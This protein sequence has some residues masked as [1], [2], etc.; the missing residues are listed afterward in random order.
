MANR[1][2]QTEIERVCKKIVEGEEEF[3][4]IWN[5]LYATEN[6]NQRE[7]YEQDLKREIKKLQRYRDQIKGWIASND[8]KDKNMLVEFR[9]RIEG[10]MERFKTCEKEMKTKAYSKEGLAAVGKLDPRERGKVE[11]QQWLSQAI[12]SLIT[13]VDQAEAE[14]ETMEITVKKSSKKDVSRGEK[15]QQLEHLI[16]RNK[17]HIQRME[18]LLRMLVNGTLEPEKVNALKEDIEY[19][20]EAN[21]EPD[22]EENEG[23]YEDLSLHEFDDDISI[24]DHFSEEGLIDENETEMDSNKSMNRSLV[25]DSVKTTKEQSETDE[26]TDT[27]KVI[28]KFEGEAG[29]KSKTTA[30][31]T[32]HIIPATHPKS[33]AKGLYIRISYI[34]L[35]INL[36]LVF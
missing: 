24:E 26:E 9:R 36:L 32:A 22:F 12:D 34:T 21:Q 27:R 8:V 1:K 13:Q 31:A 23:L 11:V 7:K 14:L 35:V 19:Y 30:A 6:A 17:Y 20:I 15:Q 28:D 33:L 3:N 16:S 2:L 10:L 5:K 4:E 25:L 29:K 18:T